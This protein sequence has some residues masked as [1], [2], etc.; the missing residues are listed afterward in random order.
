MEAQ[1]VNRVRLDCC[2][3]QCPGPI[4]EVFK[5]LKDMRDRELLKVTASDPGFAR[6]IVS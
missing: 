5:S 2:G 1:N 3:M 4:M 6:D